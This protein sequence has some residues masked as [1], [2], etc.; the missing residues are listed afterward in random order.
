[1]EGGKETRTTEDWRTLQLVLECRGASDLGKACINQLA[2]R[3]HFLE[4]KLAIMLL[5][6]DANPAAELY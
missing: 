3:G 5:L 1:M 6:P 4:M 2:K